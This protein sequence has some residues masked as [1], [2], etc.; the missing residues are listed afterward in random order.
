MLTA[1]VHNVQ[2]RLNYDGTTY[3]EYVVLVNFNTDEFSD[4]Q[5]VT[6]ASAEELSMGKVS[7][8]AIYVVC[9]HFCQL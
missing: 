8:I 6:E 1:G 4:A 9:A 2:R 7:Y 5:G 3:I